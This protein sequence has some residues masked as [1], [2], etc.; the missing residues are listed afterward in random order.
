MNSLT[1]KQFKDMTALEVEVKGKSVPLSVV[2]HPYAVY[3]PGQSLVGTT[4]KKLVTVSIILEYY[5][6]HYSLNKNPFVVET[7]CEI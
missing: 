5:M 4:I 3:S 6:Y 2:L 7:I 1:V